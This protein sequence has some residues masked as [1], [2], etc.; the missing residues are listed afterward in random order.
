ME[1][2]EA[3]AAN[4]VE[5]VEAAAA[6]AVKLGNNGSSQEISRSS[7]VCGVEGHEYKALCW[8]FGAD[9][10]KLSCFIGHQAVSRHSA[11]ILMIS[12]AHKTTRETRTVLMF[13]SS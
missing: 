11:A 3:A 1:L 4:A 10:V 6:D 12:L 9:P 5:P 7:V 8:N 13:Q 2:I